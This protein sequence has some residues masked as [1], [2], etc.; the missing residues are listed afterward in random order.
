[1]YRVAACTDIEIPP[2]AVWE[3]MSDLHCYPELPGATHRMVHV[4][5]APIVARL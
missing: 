1:M 3:L 2:E 5:D 4:P